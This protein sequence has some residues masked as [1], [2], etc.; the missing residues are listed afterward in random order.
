[1]HLLRHIE[2]MNSIPNWKEKKKRLTKKEIG[3]YVNGDLRFCDYILPVIG[4]YAD[5]IYRLY[6][7]NLMSSYVLSLMKQ[8]S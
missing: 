8:K 6:E 7:R 1:M 5:A 3:D 2:T 4:I